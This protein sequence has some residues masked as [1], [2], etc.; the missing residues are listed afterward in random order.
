MDETEQVALKRDP[1]LAP[2]FMVQLGWPTV[3]RFLPSGAIARWKA[4]RAEARPYI[5]S[6]FHGVTW[7]AHSQALLAFGGDSAV[8]S[9]SR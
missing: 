2:H 5:G 4:G 3:R 7:M 1:T 6:T 9:R 8:E